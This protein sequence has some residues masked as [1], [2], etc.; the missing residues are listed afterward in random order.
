MRAGWYKDSRPGT[1]PSRYAIC[2]YELGRAEQFSPWEETKR[3]RSEVSSVVQSD[4][5]AAR[6][7]GSIWCQD[8][9]AIVFLRTE[10]PKAE[11]VRGSLGW[12]AGW[13]GTAPPA[14][15]APPPE[16]GTVQ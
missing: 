15:L 13:D 11:T 3:R 8:R 5:V 4:S 16:V 1:V 14:L 6:V 10:Y 9:R 7:S 2:P 12:S